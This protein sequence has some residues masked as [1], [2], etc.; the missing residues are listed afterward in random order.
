MHRP[1]V[2][3][4]LLC[5]TAAPKAHADD[6][7][8]AET[9]TLAF[10][11][12][13]GVLLLAGGIMLGVSTGLCDED[14]LYDCFFTMVSG[15]ILTAAV[16]PLAMAWAIDV[17]GSSPEGSGSYWAAVGGGY[18]GMAVAGLL[19]SAIDDDGASQAIGVA[20]FLI[21]PALG[22]VLGYAL[23]YDRTSAASA[24]RSPL[25]GSLIELGAGRAASLQIPAPA[26]TIGADD[27]LRVHVPLLG[28]RW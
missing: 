19:S 22:G 26:I 13:D 6:G 7:F 15:V 18:A 10:L 23:S 28:G 12:A 3:L 17:V 5:I 16:A 20:S 21:F 25:T 2:L 14:D 8:D 4:V 1:I 27:A 11:A 24:K 9:A